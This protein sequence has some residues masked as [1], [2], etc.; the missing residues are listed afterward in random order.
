MTDDRLRE[1]LTE[2]IFQHGL[3]AEEA[4]RLCIER[5]GFT[6]SDQDRAELLDE[7]QGMA[8]YRNYFKKPEEASKRR[9]D[10]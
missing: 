9:A 5:S 8:N 2:F 7:A 4:T 3:D 6:L 10:G 1:S